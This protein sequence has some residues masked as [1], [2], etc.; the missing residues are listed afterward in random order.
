MVFPYTLVFLRV[1]KE[2]G[3][4]LAS[5]LGEDGHQ[6]GR[7]S[8]RFSLTPEPAFHPQGSKGL[9]LPCHWLTFGKN[10]LVEFFYTLIGD[11]SIIETLLLSYNSVSH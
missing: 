8:G 3:E 11:F 6:A 2:L 4:L 10:R 1:R 9:Y 7:S 5:L